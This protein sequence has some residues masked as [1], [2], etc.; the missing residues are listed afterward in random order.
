MRHHLQH[1]SWPISKSAQVDTQFPLILMGETNDIRTCMIAGEGIWKWQLY[2]QLQ[3]GSK[4]ITHELLSQL[5]PVCF[6]Q[7]R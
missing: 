1:K 3:N 5:M 2:D 4:E 6:N 7:I